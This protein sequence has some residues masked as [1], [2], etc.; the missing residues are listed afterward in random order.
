MNR[1]ANIRTARHLAAAALAIGVAATAGACTLPSTG[2]VST[3]A[4]NNT[5]GATSAAAA[6]AASHAAAGSQKAKLGD[7]ITLAGETGGEKLT[8]TLVKIVTSGVNSTDGF[9]SPDSGNRYVAVQFRLTNSGAGSYS[10]DPYL[11]V[12]ILDAAGQS[13]QP[14][15]MMTGSTAGQGFAS[16][17]DIAPGD[18]QL[19]FVIVQMPTKDSPADVQFS[20]DSGLGATAQWL[21]S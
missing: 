4:D 6:G 14:D 8:V 16:T 1:S 19:G 9:S 5:H 12:Q 15:F 18:S 11:D 13:F 17:V 2:G 20:L 3:S 21:A 10:D 7:S